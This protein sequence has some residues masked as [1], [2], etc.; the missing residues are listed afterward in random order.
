MHKR[1]IHLKKR[2]SQRWYE[3]RKLY[4]TKS[5]AKDIIS[6]LKQVLK[7]ARLMSKKSHLL[8]E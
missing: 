2:R 6:Y 7:Y 4:E 3:H 5:L 8:D 1:D